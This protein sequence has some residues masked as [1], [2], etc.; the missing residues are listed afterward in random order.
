MLIGGNVSRVENGTRQVADAKTQM[1]DIVA[2]VEQV[3]S[4]IAEI[5]D[6]TREQSAGIGQVCDAVTQLDQVTQ[7]NA[8]LVQESAAAAESIRSLSVRLAELVRVFDTGTPASSAGM[9]ASVR[10]G[11]RSGPGPS[12]AAAARAA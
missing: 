12:V 2:Q 4:L 6:A 8:A 10:A 11:R 5:T 1:A 3:S 7:Q 9:S